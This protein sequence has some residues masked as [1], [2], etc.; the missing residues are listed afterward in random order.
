MRP[1]GP[2]RAGCVL[3]KGRE[4]GEE[5][6]VAKREKPVRG[7]GGRGMIYDTQEL[8]RIIE[9]GECAD[10]LL[11][12]HVPTASRRFN[13]ACK[14]LKSLMNDIRK[15]FPEATYY[16]ASG[17]LHIVLG[18][19]HSG[20]DTSPNSELTALSANNGLLIGDGDW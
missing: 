11:R 8:K 3:E 13:T 1:Q 15:T 7:G 19:T 9:E 20:I 10:D 18:E 6:G 16:T 4:A 14:S 17:G 2:L 12:E 5:G